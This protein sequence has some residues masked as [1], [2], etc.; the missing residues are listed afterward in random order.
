MTAHV[1]CAPRRLSDESPL[2]IPRASR[3]CSRRSPHRLR[4]NFS[5]SRGP[6]PRRP[7]PDCAMSRRDR[8]VRRLFSNWASGMPGPQSA[9]VT[10]VQ[11]CGSDRVR[12]RA[13]GL[14]H[15]W[16]VEADRPGA[17][18]AE[19]GA[20]RLAGAEVLGLSELSEPLPAMQSAARPVGFHR[21]RTGRNRPRTRPRTGPSG[22]V[23]ES[24]G[25]SSRSN[26]SSRATVTARSCAGADRDER[27]PTPNSKR[28][29]A[30]MT[31]SRSRI[32]MA[33]R[34]RMRVESEIRVMTQPRGRPV[35]ASCSR[36]P[37][38]SG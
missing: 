24:A 32:L 1:K 2:R 38:S 29:T 36:L 15:V 7:F 22:P 5:R 18:A 19:A 11:R 12:L 10:H 16:T 35:S 6:S 33:A 31:P 34:I 28:A 26:A 25:V 3:S 13:A 8:T 20:P 17:S 9:T 30:T 14:R 21:S 4:R 23:R 27:I 37:E